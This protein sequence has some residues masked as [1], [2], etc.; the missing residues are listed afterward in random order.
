[1]VLH[2]HGMVQH[3]G[4]PDKAGYHSATAISLLFGTSLY[5]ALLSFMHSQAEIR[6]NDIGKTHPW[7]G[8]E[9]ATNS[10]LPW[11]KRR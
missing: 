3:I 8:A 6:P 7:N 5:K 9:K 4:I 2:W 1:M 11:V 10:K